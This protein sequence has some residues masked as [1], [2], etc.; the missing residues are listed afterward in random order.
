MDNLISQEDA[1]FEEESKLKKVVLISLSIFLIILVTSYFLL[2]Y[3]IFPILASIF[4]SKTTQNNVID[5]G[6]FYIVFENGTFDKLQ[7]LYRGYPSTEFVSCLEG[8]INGSNYIISNLY[9]PQI[10]DQSFNHVTFKRCSDN[11]LILLHSHPYKRCIASSQDLKTL[12]ELKDTN[13]DL[14]II[15]MCENNRFSVYS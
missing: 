6:D 1:Y 13:P 9:I 15:I 11:A 12:E 4:E 3:P 10:I 8:D 14:I 7:R 2:S 5:L